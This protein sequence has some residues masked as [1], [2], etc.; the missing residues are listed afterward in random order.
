MLFSEVRKA[1]ELIKGTVNCLGEPDVEGDNGYYQDVITIQ[2]R[3]TK[4]QWK[5]SVRRC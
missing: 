4:N 2:D 3:L 5:T 1:I